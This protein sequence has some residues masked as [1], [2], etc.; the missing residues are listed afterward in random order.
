MKSRVHPEEKKEHQN[1]GGKVQKKK[2]SVDGVEQYLAQLHGDPAAQNG[3]DGGRSQSWTQVR[4]IYILTT[5]SSTYS[6]GPMLDHK[7]SRPNFQR[8]QSLE[9][10]SESVLMM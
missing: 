1:C 4:A 8:A 9:E 5:L 2:K 10:G 7:A 6:H 3:S